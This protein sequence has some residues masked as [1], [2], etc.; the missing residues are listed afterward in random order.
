MCYWLEEPLRRYDFDGLAE[1]RRIV[2]I[3]LAGGENN[4]GVQEFLWM[5]EK[6][7]YDI[8][9]PEIL[10]T[11]GVQGLRAV[12]ALA[13]ANHKLVIHITVAANSA[14]SRPLGP[15]IRHRG[16]APSHGRRARGS[17]RRPRPRHVRR[18]ERGLGA[19]A[20]EGGVS[21]RSVP[22]PARTAQRLPGAA[23]LPPLRTIPRCAPGRTRVRRDGANGPGT[24]RR[25]H[26]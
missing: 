11:E 14:R 12:A 20:G 16:R 5:I 23:G 25:L 10:F 24:G 6:G 1:L 15:R 9:Q 13:L 18:R 2:D 26:S 19:G 3:Q 8:L 21:P 4:Q 22:A 7:V 17:E